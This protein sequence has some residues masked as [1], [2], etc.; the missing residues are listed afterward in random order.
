MLP[1]FRQ[2]EARTVAN[3]LAGLEQN[4]EEPLESKTWTETCQLAIQYIEE[5]LE[6]IRTEQ[7]IKS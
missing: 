3:L 2:I 4:S 6:V 5:L 1:M 7:N